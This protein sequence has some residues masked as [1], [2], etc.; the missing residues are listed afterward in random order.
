MATHGRLPAEGVTNE[1]S[2]DPAEALDSTVARFIKD[3]GYVF[4]ACSCCGVNPK[5]DDDISDDD[6]C[7]AFANSINRSHV[8]ASL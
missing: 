7:N 4:T 8:K 2:I 6:F 1:N 3:D 5:N